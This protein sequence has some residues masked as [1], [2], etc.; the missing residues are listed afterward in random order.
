MKKL[1]LPII[2]IFLISACAQAPT[3]TTQSAAPEAAPLATPTTPSFEIILNPTLTHIDMIDAQNGW[4]QAEGMI[5]R[6]EDGGESWLNITPPDII[7][8]PTYSKSFFIDENIGWVLLEDIDK[9]NAGLIYRTT[10]GGGL[11][12]W[13]NVPFGRA[14]F[15]FIDSEIGYALFSTGAAAGSMGVSI[16]TTTNGGGDYGRVFFH[17]PGFAYTLPFSGIKNGISFR[18]EENGWVGG[19]VPMD[20]IIWLYRSVDAGLSWAEQKVDL[21]AGYGNHQTSTAAPIFFDGGLATLPVQLFGE[22]SGL[23]FYQSQNG[24]ETWTPTLPLESYGRYA[25]PSANEIIVWDGGATIH[26]T[27]DGGKSWTL[28]ASNWQPEDSLMTLDFININE[29]WA[30]TEYELYKTQDGGKTWEKLGE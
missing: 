5:L 30:R 23:V 8:D 29:G 3:N 4:G 2:L 25:I 11:W 26:T 17:E 28:H 24:G 20:G 12:Q 15:G 18:D 21:P 1:S 7:S 16:W 10:N 27:N 13:R 9:P 14:D 22:K 6:T 19:T